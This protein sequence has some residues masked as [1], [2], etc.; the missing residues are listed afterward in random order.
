LDE[1]SKGKKL[2]LYVLWE[3][4]EKIVRGKNFV[5]SLSNSQGQVSRHC[6]QR[7]KIVD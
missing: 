7:E 3:K 5:L 4:E 1:S 6:K 2:F